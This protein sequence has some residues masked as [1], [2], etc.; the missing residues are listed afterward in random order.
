MQWHP[1]LLEAVYERSHWLLRPFRL[2]M[3]SGGVVERFFVFFERVFK[4]VIFD[5]CQCGQCV[6]HRAGMTCPMTCPKN[7]RNGPCGGVTAS[8]NCE[9]IPET[10]CVWL[11]AWERSKEMRVY[12]DEILGILPPRKGQL[13][14]G[15]AWINGLSGA[16]GQTPA[17]WAE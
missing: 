14:G 6:L 4:G 8:G 17:G 9:I 10:K 3:V 1:R 11:Q 12:G 7:M 5:C 2:W 15:S 16:A 13:D